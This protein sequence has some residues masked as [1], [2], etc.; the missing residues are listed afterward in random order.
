MTRAD[1]VHGLAVMLPLGLT[2]GRGVCGTDRPT[3]VLHVD[4]ETGKSEWFARNQDQPRYS[5]T[6]ECFKRIID[7][8]R[9]PNETSLYVLDFGVMEF[10]DMSP[11]FAKRKITRTGES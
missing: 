3:G 1:L 9:G 8:K 2:G 4:Q 5:R 11:P 10:T 7:V 6:G